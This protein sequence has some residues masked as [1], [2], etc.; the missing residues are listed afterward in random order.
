[1]AAATT[2]SDLRRHWQLFHYHIRRCWE[3]ASRKAKASKIHKW[4]AWC[5]EHNKRIKKDP[6]LRYLWHARNVETHV[7]S[8]TIEAPQTLAFVER[9]GRRF[10]PKS[11]TMA[12]E[13]STLVVD[14][15]T[16]ELY[17]DWHTEVVPGD[18]FLLRFKDRQ[19][20]YNPPTQHLGRPI[21]NKQHP[22]AIARLGYE[23][24]K[25]AIEELP[26]DLLRRPISQPA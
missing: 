1:M 3:A 15:Q 7:V 17:F 20:W 25:A 12:L 24:Y 5:G 9:N 22:A 4:E 19:E 13:G 10:T 8:Q 18:P 16:E 23:Y 26:A 2:L 14:V 21:Q 6:L 11:I